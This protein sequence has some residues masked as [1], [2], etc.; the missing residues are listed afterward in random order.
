MD[1]KNKLSIVEYGHCYLL[2]CSDF[3]NRVLE[4][5]YE[6]CVDR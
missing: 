1:I 5:K 4:N 6:E 2:A 3:E